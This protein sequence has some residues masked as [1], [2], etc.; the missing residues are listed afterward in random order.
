MTTVSNIAYLSS[1]RHQLS[2]YCC[3]GLSVH[4]SWVVSGVLIFIGVVNLTA[5][6]LLVKTSIRCGAVGIMVGEIVR[7]SSSHFIRFRLA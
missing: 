2:G 6:R 3:L 4:N 7:V 1:E 5:R